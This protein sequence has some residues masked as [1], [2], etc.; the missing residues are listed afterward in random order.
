[1]PVRT[2][3]VLASVLLVATAA[4]ADDRIGEAKHQVEAA[5]VDYK[6]GRFG[7]ALDKYSKAYELYPA[8]PLLFNIGQ[9]HK[10][11]RNYDKAIFFFEGY[12]R[13]NPTA[14]NRALV[15]DPIRESKA[16]RDKQ[17]AVVA[18]PAVTPPLVAPPVA[19]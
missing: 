19:V 1:M 3:I 15:E 10:N 8:A 14:S 4:R 6:L 12:L 9:C 7:D 11:L 17:P 16:E 5:D 2:V 18:P 13:D